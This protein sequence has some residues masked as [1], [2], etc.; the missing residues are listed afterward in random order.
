MLF[1]SPEYG[2]LTVGV[3]AVAAAERLF[4]V[5]AGAFQPK[6]KVDSAVL[7]LVPRSEPLVADSEREGF[8]RLVVGL[9][10]FRRKQL[11][12]G[13]RELTSWE[14]GPAAAA[15]CTAGIDERA[16][17]EVLSPADFVRL[18]RVVDAA[19]RSG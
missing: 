15:L 7:R 10:G 5:P 17:P 4:T 16:R 13:L 8:R 19:S 3:Q 12:R 9:F 1:R 2:A 14:A 6:P 18:Y 11:L